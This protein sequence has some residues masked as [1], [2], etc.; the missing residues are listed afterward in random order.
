[1]NSYLIHK[2]FAFI[3]V[4]FTLITCLDM[5]SL[6]NWALI[7]CPL[8]IINSLSLFSRVCCTIVNSRV[9]VYN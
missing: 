1:L 2:L 9:Q 6:S 8:T 5:F 7:S 4:C 3:A